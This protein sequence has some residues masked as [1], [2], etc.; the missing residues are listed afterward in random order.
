MP[1]LLMNENKNSTT[2]KQ[3][4]KKAWKNSGLNRRQTHD[5]ATTNLVLY[6]LSIQPN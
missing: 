2:Y 5:H 1:I 4:Q 6:Q 3:L